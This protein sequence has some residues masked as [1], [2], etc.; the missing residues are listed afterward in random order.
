[1]E[2]QEQSIAHKIGLLREAFRQVA[3]PMSEND[4]A[5]LSTEF[6][7]ADSVQRPEFFMTYPVMIWKLQRQGGPGSGNFDN[8]VGFLLNNMRHAE[9]RDRHTVYLDAAECSHLIATL[10]E[11][12][13]QEN[14]QKNKDIVQFN[15]SV[16]ALA[17]RHMEE[18][19]MEHVRR[20]SFDRDHSASQ[21]ALD[22][23]GL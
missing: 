2:E 13:A 7:I 4:F 3:V 19:Q 5:R 8:K 6:A 21:A 12:M 1:M 20:L 22:D 23:P 18:A 17:H 16:L 9:G 14:G 15:L 11:N 10:M